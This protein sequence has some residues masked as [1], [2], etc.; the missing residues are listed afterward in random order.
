VDSRTR[1]AQK[2]AATAAAPGRG[3]RVAAWRLLPPEGRA[4]LRRLFALRALRALGD[5]YVA[6]LLPA[7]LT[8]LGFSPLQ[9]GAITAATLLGSGAMVL[10]L[11]LHAHRYSPRT[12]VRGA[13]ALMAAC[14]FAFALASDFWPLLMVAAVST[15]NPAAGDVSVFVP[16]EQSMIAQRVRA[17]HRT[18]VFARYSLIGGLAG[19]VG[20]LAAGL[21]Q[22]MESLLGLDPLF[23][24]KLM[25]VLHGVFGL[26]ALVAYRGLSARVEPSGEAPAA[27]LRESRPL[28]VRMSLVFALDQ[29]GSGFAVQAMVALWLYA[30][31]DLSASTVGQVFFVA[32]LL[33]SGSYLVSSWVARRIGL[34]NT[35]VWTHLP[36]NVFLV[37]AAFMPD[38]FWAITLLL[39]R[40]SLSSMDVPVRS[41]WVMAVVPPHERAAAASLTAVP[42]SLATGVSPFIAGWMLG[43]SSFGW[44]LV[45]GG[46]LKIG[47]D[48]LMLRMFSTVRPPEE[49]RARAPREPVR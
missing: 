41:S 22:A 45:V 36:A 19:S 26:V 38:A 24:L 18:A 14:G 3:L 39:L 21:P 31:F 20:A 6:L 17:R 42:R 1:V 35:M 27:P 9:V 48:L 43:L 23:A 44:P 13:A 8:L 2:T 4:D 47:Y 10:A 5:G 11:G 28:V 37:A 7:Y 49:Q 32:G 25:F 16:L 12:L 34:V 40:Y 15:L 33:A 29:F 30:R 46:V